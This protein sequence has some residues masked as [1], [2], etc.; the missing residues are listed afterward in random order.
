MPNSRNPVEEMVEGDYERG[1][2]KRSSSRLCLVTHRYSWPEL[3]N[4]QETAKELVWDQPRSS[5]SGWQFHSLIFCGPLAVRPRP[6]L[7]HHMALWN[8]LEL[9]SLDAGG[10][11]RVWSC[12]NL[13]CHVLLI[14]MGGFTPSKCSW[15]RSVCQGRREV[16]RGNGKREW[17]ENC[18]WSI[19]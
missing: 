3:M 9:F 12:F 18:G 4:S 10:E 1:E 16:R 11:G 15:R 7:M 13:I 19:K 8:Y 5:T 6:S 17:R 14:P 2:G